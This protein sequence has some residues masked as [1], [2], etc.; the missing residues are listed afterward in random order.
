MS[1]G[2]GGRRRWLADQANFGTIAAGE[3]INGPTQASMGGAPKATARRR[4]GVTTVYIFSS[5]ASE[6]SRRA[7]NNASTHAANCS[8]PRIRAFRKA[9]GFLLAAARQSPALRI[10]TIWSGKHAAHNYPDCGKQDCYGADGFACVKVT[11]GAQQRPAGGL[12]GDF[13]SVQAKRPRASHRSWNGGQNK[14]I[15]PTQLH[16]RSGRIR[17]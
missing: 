3:Y 1:T 5:H 4:S 9:L 16:R 8:P 2:T 14:A 15:S 12:G 7:S 17:R 11:P 13:G 10:R 6:Y